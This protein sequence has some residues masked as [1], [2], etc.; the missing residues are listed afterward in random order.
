MA[1][2]I[3]PASRNPSIDHERGGLREQFTSLSS[4]ETSPTF[5]PPPGSAEAVR[6][7]AGKAPNP[8]RRAPEGHHLAGPWRAEE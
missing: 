2:N 7:L 8:G 5:C 4:L 1:P 6:A 3:F